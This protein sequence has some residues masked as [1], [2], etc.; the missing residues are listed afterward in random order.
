LPKRLIKTFKSLSAAI[1]IALHDHLMVAGA[2]CVSF[3]SIDHL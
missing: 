1:G 3:K 2:N